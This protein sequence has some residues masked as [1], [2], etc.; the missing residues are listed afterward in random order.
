MEA[1]REKKKEKKTVKLRG[2]GYH[3]E[4]SVDTEPPVC[5]IITIIVIIFIVIAIIIIAIINIANFRFLCTPLQKRRR[6]RKRGGGEAK[7]RWRK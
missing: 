5:F 6:R 3:S 7:V 2:L 1:R 4:C